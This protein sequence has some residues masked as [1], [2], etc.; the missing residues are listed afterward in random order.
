MRHYPYDRIL[1]YPNHYCSTCEFLKPARS[2]HCSICKSCVARADHH[3]VWVNNCVG[4]GNYRYFLSLLLS[5]TVLLAYGAFL[6]WT[7]L[8]PRMRE[9]FH[10]Y[11][12]W[13]ASMSRDCASTVGMM[14]WALCKFGNF[15]DSLEVAL[16]VGG[17]EI[18]GVGLLMLFTWPMPLG[19]LGYHVY[20]IWA[21]TTTNESSKWSDCREDMYEGIIFVGEHKMRR[22]GEPGQNPD[23][24]PSTPWPTSS[25]FA[26]LKTE[27]GNFPE[28]LPE[29]L[30]DVDKNSW[31]RCYRL[32]QVENIYDLGFWDNLMEV[33]K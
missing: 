5:S 23:I 25:R 15:S 28:V 14:E 4:R 7:I 2:K 9:H 30:Q 16:Q 32:S 29:I 3:C 20:L 31:K 11:A 18:T 24:E 8:K 1:Y 21:G 22:P 27:D 19:L 17:L 10:E 26:L 33:F 13:Y 6:A 12:D